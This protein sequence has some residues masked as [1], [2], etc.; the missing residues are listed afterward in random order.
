VSFINDVKLGLELRGGVLHA[1]PQI[2]DVI[3]APIAGGIDFNHIRCR[4]GIDRHAGGTGIAR[5]EVW[6][7]R[8]AIDGLGQEAGRCG[9]SCAARATEEIGVGDAVERDGVPQRGDDMLLPNKIIVR[10]RG[11]PILAIERV[12]GCW[13]CGT[14]SNVN[15]RQIEERR[16]AHEM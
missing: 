16:V 8:Q 4:V 11:G 10:E 5:P 14:R 3:N 7:W 6:I 13:T 2:P 12:S 15:W 1:L 9:F